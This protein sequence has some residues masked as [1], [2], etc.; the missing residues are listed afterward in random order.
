MGTVLA[1]FRHGPGRAAGGAPLEFG[2]LEKGYC[3]SHG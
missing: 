2:H 1:A 3:M